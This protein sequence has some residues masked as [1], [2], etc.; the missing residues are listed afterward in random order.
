ME[1]TERKKKSSGR[2]TKNG[3]RTRGSQES[4]GA[5]GGRAKPIANTNSKPMCRNREST[6]CDSMV[7]TIWVASA[8]KSLERRLARG[9]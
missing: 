7:P 2:P 4:L 9:V 6:I 5:S 1:N 8:R 3:N